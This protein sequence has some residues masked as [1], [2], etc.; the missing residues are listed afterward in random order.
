M[1]EYVVITYGPDNRQI[2]DHVARRREDAINYVRNFLDKESRD[3]AF[4]TICIVRPDLRRYGV[5]NR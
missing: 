4:L 2:G 5:S 3:G 1:P